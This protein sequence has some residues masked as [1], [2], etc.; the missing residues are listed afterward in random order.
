MG[1]SRFAAILL[2]ERRAEVKILIE[3]RECG[4]A[5]TSP[6]PGHLAEIINSAQVVVN[7]FQPERDRR[8]TPL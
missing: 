8:R 1:G 6:P 5:P 4:S 7:I 3:A 2:D